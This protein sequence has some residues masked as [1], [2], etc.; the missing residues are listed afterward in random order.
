MI[1]IFIISCDRLKSLKKTIKSYYNYIET[2]FEIVIRDN[3]STFEPIIEFLKDLESKRIKVYWAEKVT[4]QEGLN[5]LDENIQDYF[6]THPKTNYIVTDN[7]IALDNVEGDILEVYSYLLG[8]ISEINVVGTML[9][10]D[11]IPNCYPYKKDLINGKR[12][13]HKMFHLAPRHTINYKGKEIKY[14]SAFIDTTFGMYRKGTHWHRG[15][16]G[17][18][19]CSP[20]SSKHLD[21]YICPE[22]LTDDQKYYMEHSSK[23]ISHWSGWSERG[24][25][26]D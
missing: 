23:A 26:Y 18:R 19:T 7:D 6:R 15:Q 10:I 22:N 17:I 9:R 12:G 16:R 4:N 24:G 25:V 14:I 5:A 1:P 2:P 11:D 3:G 8:T 13:L 20:Y 21:W